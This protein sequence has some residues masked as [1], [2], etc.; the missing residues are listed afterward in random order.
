MFVQWLNPVAADCDGEGIWYPF[1]DK[2]IAWIGVAIYALI[3]SIYFFWKGKQM[4]GDISMQKAIFWGYGFFILGYFCSRVLFI[5]SDIERW[6]N[7][8]TTLHVQYV[9]FSYTIGI[10]SALYLLGIIEKE[11]LH[12]EKRY[13]T[14]IYFS[15]AI[16]ALGLAIFASFLIDYIDQIRLINTIISTFGAGLLMVLYMRIIYLATGAIRKQAIMI[17]LG[18]VLIFIGSIIDGELIIRTL[19]IP[20]WFPSIFPIVGFTFIL[21]TLR[22]MGVGDED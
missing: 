4:K 7:C 9:L 21:F 20:I 16:L 10:F 1:W 5:F 2:E 19:Q 3:I 15:I 17:F 11:V 22:L 6:N 13:M 14:K 8:R 18:I 12:F